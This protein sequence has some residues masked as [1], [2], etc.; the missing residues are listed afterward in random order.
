[1][2]KII[3]ILFLCCN[4]VLLS[5]QTKADSFLLGKELS[6]NIFRY[7]GFMTKEHNIISSGAFIGV[8]NFR[9]ENLLP[10]LSVKYGA[11]LT[12]FPF[13]VEGYKF[14][15]KAK[16][17]NHNN[18]PVYQS[19]DNT[20]E[21]SGWDFSMSVCPIPYINQ[22]SEK[23]VPYIGIGYQLSELGFGELD[24]N[25]K[26]PIFK[27]RSSHVNSSAWTWKIGC[28]FYLKK[29]PFHVIVDYERSWNSKNELTNFYSLNVGLF[30]DLMKWN[31]KDKIKIHL[32]H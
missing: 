22:W 32:P 28:N 4:S 21:H 16:I 25:L 23:I 17:A 15:G 18:I 31:Y 19:I 10:N 27:L 6:F 1:M 8:T 7:W 2:K 24:T 20:L 30:L 9:N 11:K 12:V 26:K 3:F 5:A 14:D 13:V 29:L